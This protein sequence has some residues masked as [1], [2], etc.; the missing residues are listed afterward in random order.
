MNQHHPSPEYDDLDSRPTRTERRLRQLRP[1]SV[2]FDAETIL[3][4]ARETEQQATLSDQG[5]RARGGRST[6]WLTIGASWSCGAIAGM[7][8]TCLVLLPRD[9]D[10]QQRAPAGETRS[11]HDA[12]GS[13]VAGS[14]VERK[15][16]EESGETANRAPR[17]PSRPAAPLWTRDEYRVSSQ[18]LLMHGTGATSETPLMAGNYVRLHATSARRHVER[19][20][21]VEKVVIGEPETRTGSDTRSLEEATRPA[22]SIKPA[23]L[24]RE[25]LGGQ[26]TSHL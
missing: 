3:R 2:Q 6:R 11:E 19:G 4:A 22:L 26:T 12:P 20:P 9:M 8:L 17:D 15:N 23:P 16:R 25:L 13:Q 7:L 24:L 18:L 21:H 1:R 14:L 5:V 10:R